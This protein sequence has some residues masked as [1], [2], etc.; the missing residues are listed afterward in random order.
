MA[1][2]RNAGRKPK[3]GVKTKLKLLQRKVPDANYT[4]IAD[5]IDKMLK[6]DYGSR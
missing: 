4:E 2:E 3:Y 5:K 6:E 1:N